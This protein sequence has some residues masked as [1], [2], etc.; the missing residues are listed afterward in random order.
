MDHP[1]PPPP[2][3]PAPETPPGPAAPA[4]APAPTSN[5]LIRRVSPVRALVVVIGAFL[6]AFLLIRTLA[7]E[8]F[9]VPTGSM[10]PALSGHHRD[11]A[12]PRCG[13]LARVGRPSSGSLNDHFARVT[14]L[15]C[16]QTLSLADARDLSG[17]RL[18]VD[19]NVYELRRPRRWEMV[20][21][22]CPNPNPTELGKP[23]VKRLIGLPGETITLAD[24]DVFVNGALARKGLAEVRETAVPVFDLSFQPSFGWAERWVIEKSG[25]P[26]LPPGASPPPAAN[27]LHNKGLV[28]DAADTPQPVVAVRYR[29]WNLDD[30]AEEPIR[31]WSAY[32]GLARRRNELPAAHDFYL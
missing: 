12:C 7:A 3:S 28:L 1:D 10:A 32:D 4:L 14:C 30:R 23:Y 25:D 22:R 13:Y 9:G 24:G 27:V 20:V 19:K 18:L 6:G 21:F 16:D 15:N 31:A 2:A 26:R 8:P 29:N 11:G 17:D 5:R